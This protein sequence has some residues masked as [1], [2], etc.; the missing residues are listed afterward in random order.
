MTQ[1]DLFR[2]G[3]ILDDFTCFCPPPKYQTKIDGSWH[4]AFCTARQSAEIANKMLNKA[5]SEAPT[6]YGPSICSYMGTTE[7]WEEWVTKK[8]KGADQQAKLVAIEEIK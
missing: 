1:R 6:V 3:F 2:D 8:Y 7:E 4:L 5:I